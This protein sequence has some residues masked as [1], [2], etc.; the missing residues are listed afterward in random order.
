[1]RIAHQEV[2][3]EHQEL[4]EQRLALRDERTALR[5]RLE[6]KARDRDSVRKR[7]DDLSLQIAQKRRS[8]EELTDEMAELEVAPPEGDAVLPTVQEAEASVRTLDRKV[9]NLGDVNMRAKEQ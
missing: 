8:L 1:M 7:I 2:S 5:T 9:S 3:N 6:Q 4:D